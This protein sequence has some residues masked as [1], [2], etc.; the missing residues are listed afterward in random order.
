MELVSTTNN[1][2]GA[3]M[4]GMAAAVHPWY[5]IR[6]RSRFEF[7]T[8]SVL[9]DK[10]FERLLPLYRSWRR[11]SDRV[12]ELD[13]PL[14]PG[15]VFCRFDASSPLRVLT[16]PGVVHIVSAGRTPI[17]VDEH[18]ISVLQDICGSGLP[19][20]PWP[21]L[22]VGRRVS[23]DRGPLAGTEG[24]V[25]ELKGRCRLVA[26]ITLLQRSVAAEIDRDWIRPLH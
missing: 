10:G 22:E 9:R 17:P 26:S 13:M 12:K 7:T 16:T 8:S 19:V 11:W 24:I 21:Y 3:F 1:P 4:P 25:V 20:Q 14:F 23:I 2:E 18:E 15:Y 6:V 5:A